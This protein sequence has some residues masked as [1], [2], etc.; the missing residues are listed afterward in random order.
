M[1]SISD[2]ML[3]YCLCLALLSVCALAC[4]YRYIAD[5]IYQYLEER[6]RRRLVGKTVVEDPGEPEPEE[7]KADEVKHWYLND[8]LQISSDEEYEMGPEDKDYKA[9]E[10]K[11]QREKR[12]RK[13]GR[14]RSD[15]SR[16]SA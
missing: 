12:A 1:V 13:H 9:K 11:R 4:F 8:V 3:V 2:T 16:S 7:T 14:K 10:E 5:P 15:A 6:H